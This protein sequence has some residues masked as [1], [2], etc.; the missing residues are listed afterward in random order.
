[1]LSVTYVG[2]VY[3]FSRFLIL[4]TVC[5]RKLWRT[6]LFFLDAQGPMKT[7]RAYRCANVSI[8]K[9]FDQCVVKVEKHAGRRV[10]INVV[11]L[12]YLWVRNALERFF[13]ML[14]AFDSA[15]IL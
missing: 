9:V 15:K 13:I 12:S 8:T 11:K 3:H 10:A 14:S 7:L 6:S 1:M 4:D 2:A 5:E